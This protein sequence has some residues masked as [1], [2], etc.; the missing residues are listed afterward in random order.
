[1]G[2]MASTSINIGNATSASDGGIIGSLPWYAQAMEVC[3]WIF[4]VA[5]GVGNLLVL[6]MATY[7]RSSKHVSP[8]VLN[9]T[10]TVERSYNLY[11]YIIIIIM[12]NPLA[13]E[14]M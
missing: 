1:M 9:T 11:D 12:T 10:L 6:T 7:R 14:Y 2:S 4:I 3:Y 8:K 13:T 5:G